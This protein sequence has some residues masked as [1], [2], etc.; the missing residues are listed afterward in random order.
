MAVRKEQQQ[1]AYRTITA[2]LDRYLNV[3]VTPSPSVEPEP[4]AARKNLAS[5]GSAPVPG[6]EGGG[7]DDSE[8]DDGDIPPDVHESRA[9]AGAY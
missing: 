5:V 8:D 3:P 4:P 6:Y 2:N 1:V 9:L 7:N